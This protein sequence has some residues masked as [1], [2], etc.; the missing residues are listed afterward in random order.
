MPETILEIGASHGGVFGTNLLHTYIRYTDPNGDKI[1]IRGTGGFN[2]TLQIEVTP[3][4]FSK[5]YDPYGL[6]L[7]DPR[8]TIVTVVQASVGWSK[9]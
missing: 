1:I 8:V 7:M 5:D 2:R 9:R 4:E 6:D 3:E